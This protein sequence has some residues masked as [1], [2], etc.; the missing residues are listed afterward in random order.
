M[1]ARCLLAAGC[2]HCTAQS[3]AIP[4]GPTSCDPITIQGCLP[5]PPLAAGS[6]HSLQARTRRSALTQ[7]IVN[8]S[9]GNGEK[10]R[11]GGQMRTY[12]WAA[13]GMHAD[14]LPDRNAH[15][16]GLQG[17]CFM[18]GWG[19]WVQVILEVT[20]PSPSGLPHPALPNGPCRRMPLE[21]LPGSVVEF[22]REVYTEV[23]KEFGPLI[24]QL[25]L[26]GWQVDEQR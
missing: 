11:S 6:L 14:R 13:A 9:S 22:K 3:Y 8:S 25:R 17:T 2:T 18:T 5:A 16:E 26:A 15:R 24:Q 10:R 23:A 21:E 1:A 4:G 12:L 20:R 19:C 7:S